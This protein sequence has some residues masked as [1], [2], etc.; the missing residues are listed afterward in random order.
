LD[1][2]G[3]NA[4]EGKSGAIPRD[5]S[6]ILERLGLNEDNWQTTASN[7]RRLF[8]CFAG[9]PACLIE[10]AVKAEQSWTWGRKAAKA[11]YGRSKAQRAA[12][13]STATGSPK[14]ATGSP[15]SVPKRPAVVT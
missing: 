11:A 14:S 3:R 5:M 9:A 12:R 15:K 1:H 7:F 13:N 8:P 4:R 2:T 10:A 6:P